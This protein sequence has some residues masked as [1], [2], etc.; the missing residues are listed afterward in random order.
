MAALD[1]FLG[2]LRHVVTQV[3]EAE[4][5]IRTIGNVAG[6][7]LAALSRRLTH[8]DAARG[9]TQEVVDAA[10]D[11]RLVLRQVVVDRHDVHAF[12]SQ[13]TQVGRH[14]RDQ[15]LTFTGFHFRDLAL[16]QG[17]AAHDLNVEGTHA[18]DSPRG[19]TDRR[20]GLHQ[21]VVQSL[22][23][24]QTILELLSL[25]LQLLVRQSLKVL[26]H[27]INLRRKSVQLAQH[28]AFARAKDLVNNRHE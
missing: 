5:V 2:H 19:L 17:D 23:L 25:G 7:H 27:G 20:E 13:R 24:F 8:Q 22:A 14:G 11:V 28:A 6:V 26:L 3:V 16:V 21:D 1:H 12:S 15:R 9:Q 10:H 18:Q 4:L